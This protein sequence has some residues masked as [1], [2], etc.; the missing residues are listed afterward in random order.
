MKI[1][2][3]P[4]L[5]SPDFYKGLAIAVGFATIRRV[6]Q[7]F[8]EPSIK[9]MRATVTAPV[10]HV[11]DDDKITVYGF[12]FP[13]Q[14]PAYSKGVM[15]ASP[16][17][18]RVEAFLRLLGLRYTKIGTVPSGV[19]PRGRVPY[20]NVHGK[21]IDDSSRIIEYLKEFTGKDPDADLTRE[22]WATGQLIRETI[23]GTLYWCALYQKFD[24]VDGREIFRKTMSAR[25]PP[26]LDKLI[27]AFVFRNMHLQLDSIGISKLPY[28][29]IV[30]KAENCLRA[31]S[32]ILGTKKYILGTSSPTTYDADC[33]PTLAMYFY[34]EAQA[35]KH[36]WVSRVMIECPNLLSYVDRMRDMLYP[37]LKGD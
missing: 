24:T 9:D 22:Q 20:A 8:Q 13:G 2:V 16:Y 11:G 26:V 36:L 5:F 3:P 31:L 21:M 34:D 12:E 28:D 7:L 32:K 10:K 1:D 18:S 33:Y 30:A 14:V 35:S 37:E 25:F 23:F 19:N 17:V 4:F 29:E 15:D 27:G 6:Y